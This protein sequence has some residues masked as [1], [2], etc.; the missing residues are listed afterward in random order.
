[1]ISTAANVLPSPSLNPKS[2]AVNAWPASSVI[3]NVLSVPAGAS[4]TAVTFTVRVTATLVAP[5]ESSTA[6]DSVRVGAG[7][8]EPLAKVTARSAAAN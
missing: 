7:S 5:S 6:I 3:A 8:S 2:A 1:M 4:L